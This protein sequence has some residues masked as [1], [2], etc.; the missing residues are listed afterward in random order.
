MFQ[1]WKANRDTIA[2]AGPPEACQPDE[3]MEM[4]PIFLSQEDDDDDDFGN[5]QENGAESPVYERANN[6]G[7]GEE[8]IDPEEGNPEDAPAD[9]G[10][11][12]PSPSAI[13]SPERV[14]RYQR[15]E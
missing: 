1:A 7:N 13:V 2:T 14:K 9:N 8:H 5:I 11:E 15:R 3:D 10:E 12:V 4:A 6:N